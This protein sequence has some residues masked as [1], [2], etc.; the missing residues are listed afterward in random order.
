MW[1]IMPFSRWDMSK[2]EA[3]H[4][5][6]ATSMNTDGL[7]ATKKNRIGHFDRLSEEI[8]CFECHFTRTGIEYNCC[9][10]EAM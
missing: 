4:Y 6:P 10:Y 5:W 8:G 2:A 1:Y 9:N 3:H 7:F